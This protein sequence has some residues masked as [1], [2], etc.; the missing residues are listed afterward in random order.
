MAFR[1]S[2]EKVF[3]GSGVGREPLQEVVCKEHPVFL[4]LSNG[5]KVYAED[6]KPVIEVGPEP[7]L[8]Y[9][10]AQVAVGRDY[11]PH[12]HLPAF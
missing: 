2:V 8:A 11:K 12:I 3:R 1:A 10:L 6:V 5:G 9:L 7:A 4:P